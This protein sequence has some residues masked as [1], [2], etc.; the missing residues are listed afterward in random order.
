MD[1]DDNVILSPFSYHQ[2]RV[3]KENER[4][5]LVVMRFLLRVLEVERL[6]LS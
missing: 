3:N 1:T 5:K 4:H 2:D 6:A